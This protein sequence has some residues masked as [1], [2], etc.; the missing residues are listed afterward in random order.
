MSEMPQ[1]RARGALLSRLLKANL[2]SFITVTGSSLDLRYNT[3]A[4]L[5]HCDRDSC[6]IRPKYLCHTDFSAQQST[7]HILSSLLHCRGPGV[8]FPGTH[9]STFQEPIPL[10]LIR[11]SLST[12]LFRCPR[13]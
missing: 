13:L 3:R 9:A 11:Q 12:A 7:E 2:D 1:Y 10:S 4:S 6:A 5:D 8:S